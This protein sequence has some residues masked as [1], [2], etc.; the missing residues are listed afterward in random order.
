MADQLEHESQYRK[1]SLDDMLSAPTS[2]GRKVSFE[3]ED[4]H[5]KPASETET[6][7]ASTENCLW[8]YRGADNKVYGPYTTQDMKGWWGQGYFQGENVVEIRQIKQTA[9]SIFDDADE[10]QWTRSD[11]LGHLFSS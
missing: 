1:R 9:E 8:E 10:S 3:D 5:T 6:A 2:Y 7:A 11:T 4:P